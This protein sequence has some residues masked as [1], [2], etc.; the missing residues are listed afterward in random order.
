M[1][2]G[3]WESRQAIVT[4]LKS[5]PTLTGMLAK[6]VASVFDSRPDNDPLEPT[7]CPCIVV[8]TPQD[9]WT[10]VSGNV[11]T[12]D[13]K[14]N[15]TIEVHVVSNDPD[16]AVVA[17]LRDEITDL[18]VE[19]VI[20]DCE[21]WKIYSR[22]EQVTLSRRMS[23]TDYMRGSAQVLM[24]VGAQQEIDLDYGTPTPL[25]G[26]DVTLKMTDPEQGDDTPAITASWET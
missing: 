7:E 4:R 8:D 16:P 15:I 18:A 20:G 19:S 9:Q 17:K 26:I 14:S 6:G 24:T 5:V 2:L 3:V 21:L 10:P 12:Y 25:E 13:A 11:P 23:R 22:P 1:S